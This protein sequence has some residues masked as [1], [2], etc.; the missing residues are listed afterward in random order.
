VRRAS[1]VETLWSKG[2]GLI[3]E[4]DYR[5]AL[6]TR[7]RYAEEQ[8]GK[9]LGR[10]RAARGVQAA[11][12]ALKSCEIRSSERGVVKEILKRR[13]EAIHN[14]EAVVR[15]EVQ[16]VGAA[17]VNRP[18]PGTGLPIVPGVG[19]AGVPGLVANV[20]VVNVPGRR[21]GVML[22]VGTEIKEGEKVP[23]DQVVTIKTGA[24]EQKYRR[25]KPG[26]LVE[27]GQLLARLDDRLQLLDMEVKESRVEAAEAE[28]IAAVKNR[29]EADNRLQR[30]TK[31][32]ASAAVA[33]DEVSEAK[34]ALSR[35]QAEEQAKTAAVRQTRTELKASTIVLEMYEIR[36]PVRGVVRFIGKD[37]G[38]AVKSLETVVQIEEKAKE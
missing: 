14:L 29:E 38:E 4:D 19:P 25:L 24:G 9:D 15:L 7:D 36:S 28:L 31:L 37:R 5:A 26:D 1:Q 23:A 11:V 30:L 34:Q 20:P 16:E 17:P 21:D 8:K 3:S 6:L 18:V 27:E 2:K 13:G 32:L 33:Q 22:V 35:A 12:E 10:R